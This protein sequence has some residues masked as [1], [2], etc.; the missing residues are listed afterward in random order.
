MS[1]V[2]LTWD[3]AERGVKP[4]P[5]SRAE[6]EAMNAAVD[7]YADAEL[8]ARFRRAFPEPTTGDHNAVPPTLA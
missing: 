1:R 6:W 3:E 7:S 4:V 2:R 8:R 5:Y